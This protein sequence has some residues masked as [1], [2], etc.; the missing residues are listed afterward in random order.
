M[1]YFATLIT[2]LLILVMPV[3]AGADSPDV[4]QQLAEVKAKIEQ[5]RVINAELKERL[6]VRETE[7]DELKSQ[8]KQ[9]ED[10]IA[11]LKTEHNR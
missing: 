2:P 10:Q 5:E 6:A 3:S 4:E 11:A 7:M 8:L 1:K 9:I